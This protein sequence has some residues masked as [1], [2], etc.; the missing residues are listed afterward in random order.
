[1]LVLLP[2]GAGLGYPPSSFG[3]R[4]TL[5]EG[6]CRILLTARAAV[7]AMNCGAAGAAVSAMKFNRAAAA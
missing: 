2:G 6:Q 4:L 7:S 3:S 5:P 1:M